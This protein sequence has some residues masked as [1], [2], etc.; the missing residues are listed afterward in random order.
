MRTYPF[1]VE[2]WLAAAGALSLQNYDQDGN[3]RAATPETPLTL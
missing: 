1:G 3:A 2:L